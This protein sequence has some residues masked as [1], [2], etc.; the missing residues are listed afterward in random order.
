MYKRLIV[1]LGVFLGSHVP[2]VAQTF[3][4]QIALAQKRVA[5]TMTM[6]RTV[7]TPLPAASFL[8]S[9][10]LGKSPAHFTSPFAGAYEPAPSLDRLLPIEEFKSSFFTQSNLPLV[11]LYGGRLQLVAFQST[12]HIQNVQLGNLGY[13]ATQGLRSQRQSYLGG[14]PSVDLSGLSLSFHFGRDAWTGRPTQGLR[15]MTRFVGAV[16]H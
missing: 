7:S 16:L 10:D 14:P 3:A 15:R 8:L 11:Q 5:P 9:Q 1:L 13:R 4:P 6:P 12:F 2:A